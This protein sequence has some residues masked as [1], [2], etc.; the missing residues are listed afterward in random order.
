MLE[1]RSH[2]GVGRNPF[3][4]AIKSA[5]KGLISFSFLAM[6]IVLGSRITVC[7]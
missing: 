6:A 5:P 7:A 1:S 4:P 2:D 3:V